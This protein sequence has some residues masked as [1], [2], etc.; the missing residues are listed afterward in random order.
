MPPRAVIRP[1]PPRKLV[2]A[3][4]SRASRLCCPD[5][6]RV[7]REEGGVGWGRTTSTA[8]KAGIL[9]LLLSQTLAPHL[10]PPPPA[11]GTFT[12]CFRPVAFRRGVGSKPR[13]PC[14]SFSKASRILHSQP[15]VPHPRTSSWR[16]DCL[17]SP[18]NRTRSGQDIHTWGDHHLLRD[19]RA[20]L[21]WW[22][23]ALR[24]GR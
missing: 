18:G 14:L 8:H 4:H 19:P 10:H 3:S 17:R 16:C 21:R 11:P 13:H 22:P 15:I 7:K 9:S 20:A 2:S 5:L 23:P 24:W 1:L 6:Q 12:H